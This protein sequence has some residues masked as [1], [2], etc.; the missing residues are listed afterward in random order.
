ML[1]FIQCVVVMDVTIVP[2]GA[3]DEAA[4]DSVVVIMETTCRSVA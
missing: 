1:G 3:S 4:W 2:I